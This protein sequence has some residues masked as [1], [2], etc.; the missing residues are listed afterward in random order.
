M[1]FKIKVK[2]FQSRAPQWQTT[3]LPP[4]I[5]SAFKSTLSSAL[6]S[7][8]QQDDLELSWQAFRSAMHTLFNLYFDVATH[9]ALDD[10]WL[11]GRGVSVAYLHNAKLVG[12]QRQLLHETVVSSMLMT[13]N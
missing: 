10:H 8:S 12:N 1:R 9:M 5:K 3:D 6:D 4:V 11:S 7:N 2:R 13:W